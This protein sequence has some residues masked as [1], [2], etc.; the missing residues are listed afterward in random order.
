MVMISCNLAS[1]PEFRKKTIINASCLSKYLSTEVFR[2]TKYAQ[3]IEYALFACNHSACFDRGN[4]KSSSAT[5]TR[6]ANERKHSLGKLA[7]KDLIRELF[8]TATPGDQHVKP[9]FT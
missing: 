6:W 4:L 7:V 9:S 1:K 2:S 3:T 5:W 8:T